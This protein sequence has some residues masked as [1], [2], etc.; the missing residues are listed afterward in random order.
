MKNHYGQCLAVMALVTAAVTPTA[1]G[2]SIGN[3]VAPLA[4]AG[5]SAAVAIQTFQF[6]PTPTE[7]KADPLAAAIVRQFPNR[8]ARVQ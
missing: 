6:K 4:A 1:A 2:G 8:Y 5:K 3:L 7:M